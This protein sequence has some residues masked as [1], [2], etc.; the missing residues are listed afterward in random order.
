MAESGT[1][2]EMT[3]PRLNGV[4]KA[5][6]LLLS[7]G[8][9]VAAQILQHMNPKQVQVVGATMSTMENVTRPMVETVLN[10]FL[11]LL[12]SQTALGIGNDAYI[13]GMLEKALGD[14]VG[15]APRHIND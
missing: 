14:K 12:E 5:A 8:E 2:T 3:T 9:D 11:E 1:Q 6:L 7:L 13:R 15:Q 10:D 4:E